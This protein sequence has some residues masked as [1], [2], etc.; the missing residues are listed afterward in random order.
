MQHTLPNLILLRQFVAIAEQGSISKAARVL[1]ISQPAMSKGI[2]KLEATVGTALVERFAGG[3][4]LTPA[5]ELFLDHAQV[6]ALEYDHAL[7]GIRNV[8]A[9]QDSTVNILAGP[10]WSTIVMPSILGRFHALFPRIRLNVKPTGAE[11]I[12]QA[13][14]LGRAEIFA[15]AILDQEIPDTL[16][17]NEI[18]TSSLVVLAS[19][20]HPLAQ[21]SKVRPGELARYPF[22]LFSPSSEILD[23]LA[24]YLR[25]RSAPMPKVVLETTSLQAC[26]EIVRR[27][28]FLFFETA[29]IANSSIGSGLVALDIGEELSPFKIG[30]VH[31]PGLER[32]PHLGRLLRIM[33]EAMLDFANP[34]APAERPSM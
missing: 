4:R 32:A 11:G 6:I 22:V 7:Q 29:M 28:D 13:L 5:G 3:V 10:I 20:N 25:R 14:R 17:V 30:L 24:A 19:A 16:K 18:A 23:S 8:I 21:H 9:D 31:R 34:G 26:I 12:G 1:N 15:G 33:S 27:E 2:R